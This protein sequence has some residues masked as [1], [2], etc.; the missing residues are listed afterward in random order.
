MYTVSLAAARINAGKTQK[1]VSTHLNVNISTV[2][3]W[4][5]GKTIPDALQF[6]KLCEFYK[7]PTDAIR[8]PDKFA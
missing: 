8:L 5:K 6:V 2:S 3:N 7:C 1:D 4:E